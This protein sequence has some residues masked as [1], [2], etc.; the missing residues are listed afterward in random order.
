[1]RTPRGAAWTA[2]LA[3]LFMLSPRSPT[4]GSSVSGAQQ[5]SRASHQGAGRTLTACRVTVTGTVTPT[6]RVTPTRVGVPASTTRRA[7]CVSCVTTVTMET[8]R[9]D[10]QVT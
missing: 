5:G 9:A 6:R 8:R 4:R 7:V 2:I 1:M 10:H 3:R